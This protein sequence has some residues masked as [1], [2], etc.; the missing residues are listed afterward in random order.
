MLRMIRYIFII[1]L[2]LIM[3]E[4]DLF[5]QNRN[6]RRPTATSSHRG[7]FK[8]INISRAKARVV[9]PIFEDSQYPYHGI[10]I[11][12]GDPFAFTYKFYAAKNF[13]IAIDGGKASSGLYSGYHRDNFENLIDRDT[14][15]FNQDI[16]YLGHVVKKEWVLEAKALYQ[17]DASKVLKGLQWYAGA[18]W[19][20]RDTKI[21]Y[22][23]LLEINFDENEINVINESYL[24]MGPVLVLGIEYSY[25][26]I[27]VSAFM[28][29]EWYTD[30]VQDPG[31][32]RFQ[33]GVGLR[34]IF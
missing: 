32:Q 2:C 8:Q 18:G 26:T 3:T 5:G 1:S 19:Q 34:L 4:A 11:K 30:V 16:G 6:K 17:K 20:W 28:E 31:W 22:E 33:G 27:P 7:R 23:Y 25:F 14:L 15:G 24:T 10:G 13:A 12:V 21:Q 29:I 9:C